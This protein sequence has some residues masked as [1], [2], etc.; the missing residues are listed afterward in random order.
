MPLPPL[1]SAL[2]ARLL[3]Q[4]DAWKEA[5]EVLT[6]VHDP[7]VCLLYTSPSPRD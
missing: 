7:K 4:L 2:P 6:Q 5:A 1:A 3:G